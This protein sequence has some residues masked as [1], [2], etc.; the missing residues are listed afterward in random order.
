[1]KEYVILVDEKDNMI[2]TAEKIN[3]HL[4]PKLH[5]AFSIFIVNSNGELLIQQ[6]AGNKYHCPGLWA[7]TCCG[8]PR[9]GESLESAVHRRLQEEMG[10]DAELKEIFSFTYYCK[11][12]N[13]LAEMEYDHVFIGKWNGTPIIN[14]EEVADYK[15]VA[16]DFLKKDIEKNPEIYTTWFKI[17]WEN[18]LS[19]IGDKS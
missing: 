15:W 3:A 19:K 11:F 16:K 1:M 17:A 4:E 12:D 18:L 2:G 14:Y 6:R 13:G 8:H 9:P 5:R 7:N 10:F